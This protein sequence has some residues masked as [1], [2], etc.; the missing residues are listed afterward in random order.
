MKERYPKEVIQNLLRD[1]VCDICYHK[2]TKLTEFTNW[3]NVQCNQ[4]SL[5]SCEKWKAFDLGVIRKTY[6][7][8][9]ANEI[10]SVQ[11]IGLPKKV[12]NEG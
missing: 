8:L 10:V 11:P 12:S 7:S 3:C 5:N 9:V 4:P 6:P 2:N 1:R